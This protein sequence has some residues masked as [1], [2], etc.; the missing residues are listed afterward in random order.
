MKRSHG[1]T[2]IEVVVAMAILAMISLMTWQAMDLVLKS[3]ARSEAGMA[4]ELQLQQ[5]WRLI[6][7]DLMHI[8][9]LPY[10]DGLGGTEPAYLTGS[11]QQIVRFTR[12]GEAV[13]GHNPS[14]LSRVQY[15]L[16]E[17]NLYRESLP[18]H[19]SPRDLMPVRRLLL[20]KVDAV[21]FEQPDSDNYFGPLWPPLNENVGLL[22]LPRMIRVTV[23]QADG[24][25]TMQSFPGAG[26][27]SR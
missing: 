2:L 3:N 15:V 5:T 20:E 18:A 22:S 24:S 1:F 23:V 25:Q 27:V 26:N 14:G 19:I 10:Q 21:E 13:S 12:G 7:S 9:A 16:E 4:D 6:A 11:G 17:G 8:R